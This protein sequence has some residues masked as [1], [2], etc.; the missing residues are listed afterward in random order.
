MPSSPCSCPICLGLAQTAWGHGG[1]LG[2]RGGWG[3]GCV[4]SGAEM[5]WKHS[6]GGGKA[7]EI[8]QDWWWSHINWSNMRC[9]LTDI[10]GLV[11]RS[12]WSGFCSIQITYTL[13][14]LH[15]FWDFACTQRWPRVF[16]TYQPCQP[17]PLPKAAVLLFCC[18][19][20]CFK[21]KETPIKIFYYFPLSARTE[22]EK[23]VTLEQDPGLA[24]SR[25]P[26]TVLRA[27][28]L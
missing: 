23:K 9:L 11:S 8:A 20:C 4:I 19:C 5:R 13:Q 15:L 22:P 24:T 21:L 10:F 1:W 2:W 14:D 17:L 28:V 7:E 6:K 12:C 18:C 26:V 16:W 3:E 25:G 27:D